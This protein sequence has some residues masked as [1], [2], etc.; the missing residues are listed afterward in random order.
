MVFCGWGRRRSVAISYLQQEYWP[1]LGRC[2][3]IHV[4]ACKT[5][6]SNVWRHLIYIAMGHTSGLG[7]FLLLL[8][9][10]RYGS[11]ECLWPLQPAL[12]VVRHTASRQCSVILWD[13]E[14]SI[15]FSLFY[16]FLSIQKRY[17]WPL[18]ELKSCICVIFLLNGQ[19]SLF[20]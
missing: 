16:I 13:K 20:I 1:S 8:F 5:L 14:G 3:S 2:V 6:L 7:I 18:D 4:H 12:M 9:C 17:L 11:Q 19:D 10:F 15:I